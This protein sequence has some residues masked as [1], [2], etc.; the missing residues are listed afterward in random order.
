MSTKNIMHIPTASDIED[1]D[2]FLYEQDNF[3]SADATVLKKK[4]HCQPYFSKKPVTYTEN[5]KGGTT[6]SRGEVYS[7]IYS[8]IMASYGEFHSETFLNLALFDKQTK[9]VQYGSVIIQETNS[10]KIAVLKTTNGSTLQ[11]EENDAT[12][13]NIIII[14][15]YGEIPG[16]ETWTII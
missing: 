8:L 1:I 11:F 2:V 14:S 13:C 4:L 6:S 10:T 12:P 9:F 5:N 7:T 3:V 16:T 15:P